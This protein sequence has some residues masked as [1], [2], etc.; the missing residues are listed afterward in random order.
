MIFAIDG[1]CF[2]KVI[3]KQNTL[4]LPKYGGQNLAC[5]CLHLWLLRMAFTCCCP[6]SWLP[7]WL[8]SEVVDPCFLYCHIFMQKLLFV[9]LKQLQTTLWIINA[10]LF[11]I[12]CEQ[13]RQ[14]LWMHLSHWQI[15]M[16][17]GEYTAYGY[18]QLLYNLT[19][20]QFMIGQNNLVE[21]FDVFQDN[22]RIWVTW[23]FSVIC[24]YMTAFK[25]TIPFLNPC[26][27]WSRV[28]ITL[29]KLSLCLNSI[30]PSESNAL[31]TQEIQIFSLFWKLATV[32]SLK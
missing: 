16:Q 2:L 4:H 7:I 11:L 21:F 32:A 23:A 19:Q 28:Q 29:I 12:D 24:V 17:N 26:F 15:F 3:N 27:Q 31:S 13:M 9:T 8:R 5:W 1:S 10:L 14:L 20:L 6:L 22:Y 25:V 18:L 30:F